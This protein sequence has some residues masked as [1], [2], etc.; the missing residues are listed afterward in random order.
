MKTPIH[1][2][3][4]VTGSVDGKKL[5]LEIDLSKRHGDSKS[6]KTVIVASTNGNKNVPGSEVTIGLNAYVSK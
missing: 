2:G 3:N 5:T 1:L 4:N 6:G